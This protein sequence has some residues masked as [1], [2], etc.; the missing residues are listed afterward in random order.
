MQKISE[1][2]AFLEKEEA[3]REAL[4]K[5]YFRAA[6][7]VDNVDTVLI[8]ITIGDGAG[9]VALL[10]TVIAA[11]AVMALEGTALF[12]GF[13]SI[14]G[15]Y[16]VKKSMSK[17]E[18]HEKIKTIASAKLDTITSYVSK[19]LNGNKV[20]DEEFRLILEELEKYKV[21]KE[22]VRSKTLSDRNRRNAYRE[23][24]ARSARVLLEARL[25]KSWWSHAVLEHRNIAVVFPAS[26]LTIKI[27]LKNKIKIALK[28]T[29]KI[30][31]KN[32]CS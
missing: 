27:A 5:K 14:I 10:A 11:P 4:S 8:A 6:R 17:A 28:N 2:Q 1:I 32:F 26:L 12:A 31:L 24:E 19:A 13:L 9:G 29:T 22:E 18:K 15:K 16:S 23:R 20:T 30:V 25:K 7:I 3:T 21:L